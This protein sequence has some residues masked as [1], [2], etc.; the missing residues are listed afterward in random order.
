MRQRERGGLRRTDI[1]AW[2]FLCFAASFFSV[3]IRSALV[4]CSLLCLS[5]Q[6]SIRLW[7]I[8]GRCCLENK[9]IIHPIGSSLELF[10]PNFFLKD[11][12]NRN[13]KCT[14]RQVSLVLKKVKLIIGM[15]FLRTWAAASD[16][17]TLY[18]ARCSAS[19]FWKWTLNIEYNL[20]NFII[21]MSKL[22]YSHCMLP[23]LTEFLT[24]CYSEMSGEGLPPS[25]SWSFNFTQCDL[26]VELPSD[27]VR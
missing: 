22:S 5:D 21:E 17:R 23:L 9:P 10:S 24:A 1:S 27:V 3:R 8:L 20:L 25:H 18:V 6:P 15:R 7:M 2:F 16:F 19:S 4:T 12:K 13:C 14:D 11:L 26:R